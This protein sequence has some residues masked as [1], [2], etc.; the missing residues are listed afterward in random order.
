MDKPIKSETRLL[1]NQH[2]NSICVINNL[3]TSAVFTP[4][5]VGVLGTAA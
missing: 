4:A 1:V 3:I 5:T 2:I